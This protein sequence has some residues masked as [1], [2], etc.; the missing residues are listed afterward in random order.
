MFTED[1]M[2]KYFTKIHSPQCQRILRWRAASSGPKTRILNSLQL[3]WDII[4][5]IDTYT[6]LYIFIQSIQSTPILT[7][8]IKIIQIIFIPGHI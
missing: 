2:L 4:Q 1:L 5:F 7:F 8:L 6:I 3:Y